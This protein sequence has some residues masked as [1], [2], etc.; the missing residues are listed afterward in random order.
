M[1]GCSEQSRVPSPPIFVLTSETYQRDEHPHCSLIAFPLEE[2]GIHLI[3]FS[4]SASNLLIPFSRADF[5][6]AVGTDEIT[7]QKKKYRHSSQH[8]T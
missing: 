4:D 2:I 3:F 7:Q 8:T 1:Q 5:V 6:D